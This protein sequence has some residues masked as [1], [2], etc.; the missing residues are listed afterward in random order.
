[1]EEDI[2]VSC[3][4]M[5]PSYIERAKHSLATFLVVVVS[6][7]GKISIGLKERR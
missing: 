2:D 6:V 5:C 7:M 3:G 1:V 4:R